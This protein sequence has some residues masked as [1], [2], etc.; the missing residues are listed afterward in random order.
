MHPSSCSVSLLCWILV[1]NFPHFCDSPQKKCRF[2]DS[3]FHSF[4]RKH[5]HTEQGFHTPTV[6]LTAVCFY[7]PLASRQKVC[8]RKLRVCKVS[9][10]CAAGGKMFTTQLFHKLQYF[11]FF[12]QYSKCPTAE[13][14]QRLDSPDD[15]WHS[16]SI[17]LQQKWFSKLYV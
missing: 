10:I 8:Q 14:D 17:N 5:R 13:N 15:V 7:K 12:F 2:H 3:S 9:A 11:L 16:L 4:C 1:R 6:H